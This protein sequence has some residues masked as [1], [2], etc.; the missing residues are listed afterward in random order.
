MHELIVRTLYNVPR[1][2]E[3]L[4]YEAMEE[5]THADRLCVCLYFMSEQ[6]DRSRTLSGIERNLRTIF[7][8]TRSSGTTADDFS[9][10]QSVI[11]ALFNTETLRIK[12]KEMRVSERLWENP[13]KGC[14]KN[15]SLGNERGVE[16]LE[17]LGIAVKRTIAPPASR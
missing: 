1:Q 11:R 2:Y 10:F 17:E 6:P 3:S 7:P 8:P 15:T 4:L 14:W 12:N 13:L 9:E 16:V 5:C